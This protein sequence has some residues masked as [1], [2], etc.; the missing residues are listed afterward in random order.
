MSK[1]CECAHGLVVS[2]VAP[3]WRMRLEGLKTLQRAAYAFHARFLSTVFYLT[4]N[5]FLF[6]SQTQMIFSHESS[7][8][9][10]R[11]KLIGMYVNVL[12]SAATANS[13]R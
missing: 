2:A 11:N 10:N 9:S 3:H 6:I 8:S 1:L 5:V 13:P 4:K 12:D 7:A